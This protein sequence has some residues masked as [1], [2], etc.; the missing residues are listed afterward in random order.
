[1]LTH[2]KTGILILEIEP[3]QDEFILS[4]EGFF[5]P[6]FIFGIDYLMTKKE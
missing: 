5:S 6:F 3:S 2:T 4:W 1:M